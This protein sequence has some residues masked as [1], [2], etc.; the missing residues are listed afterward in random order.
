MKIKTA[1]ALTAAVMILLS[2]CSDGSV[3]EVPVSETSET[4][5]TTT[6]SP[7]LLVRG[8]EGRELLDSIFYCGENRPLPMTLEDVPDFVLSE[9]NLI[10]PDGS[11]A[12]AVVVEEN[13][14][15]TVSAL[16]FRRETAP[17]DFSLYGIDFGAKPDDI[18]EKIGIANRVAGSEETTL[19]HRF[20]EGGITELTFTFTEGTLSEIYIAS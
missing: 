16:R 14:R 5:G 11:Y 3:S 8:W 9:G 17:A 15:H 7:Y 18:P 13:G 2:G 10:F 19:T 20:F 6:A 4:S 12:G 1:A